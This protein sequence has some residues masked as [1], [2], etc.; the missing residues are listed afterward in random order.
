[1]LED[2]HSLHPLI[3]YRLT[4]PLIKGKELPPF[5]LSKYY[6]TDPSHQVDFEFE[7]DLT[8]QK[9]NKLLKNTQEQWDEVM[10]NFK[11][12]DPAHKKELI[13][14]LDKQVKS[15][16][17][18]TEI[19]KLDLDKSIKIS[20]MEFKD[21]DF[22]KVPEKVKKQQANLYWAINVTCYDILP[23][24]SSALK[25]LENSFASLVT[26]NKG[27]LLTCVKAKVIQREIDRLSQGSKCT[28][29]IKRN[30]AARFIDTGKCDHTGEYTIFGQIYQ[31]CLK[32][33]ELFECFKMNNT[34]SQMWEVKFAGEGSIDVG[35]PF[36][37]TLSNIV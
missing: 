10:D 5:D 34:D 29:K 19:N 35:G 15:K 31:K 7:P 8:L 20:E 1:M 16:I 6:K 9:N 4:K 18:E 30:A 11:K 28:I 21:K 22:K 2:K 25:D 24:R 27:T 17:S 26:L 37:E 12:F 33:K 3:F 23:Y 13:D 14:Q 32:N 36:R